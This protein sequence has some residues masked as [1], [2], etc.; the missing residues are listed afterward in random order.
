MFG[1]VHDGG[2]FPDFQQERS[3]PRRKGCRAEAPGGSIT[4]CHCEF[5]PSAVCACKHAAPCMADP[6]I[7]GSESL[8]RLPG[9]AVGVAGRAGDRDSPRD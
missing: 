5:S 2:G 7:R 8:D 9:E 1:L 6:L 4:K 3:H